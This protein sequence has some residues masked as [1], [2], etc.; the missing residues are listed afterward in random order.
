MTSQPNKPLPPQF[1]REFIKTLREHFRLQA[2]VKALASIIETFVYQNTPPPKN[3]IELLKMARKT[4]AYQ[5]IS[6]QYA[7]DLSRL[8]GV[9]EAN[10]LARFL[11]TIPPT[12]L[13]N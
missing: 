10:E 12:Q 8:E 3:W 4:E 5:K 2:E 6:E 1:G 13:L 11:E 9:L 7:Q